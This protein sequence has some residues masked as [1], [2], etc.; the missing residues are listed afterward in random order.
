MRARTAGQPAVIGRIS[1]VADDH[2]L[3]ARLS[4]RLADAQ[5]LVVALP[6]GKRREG[7]TRRLIAVTTAAKRNLPA[8]S[9]RLDALLA[10]LGEDA[11]YPDR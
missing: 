6:E 11:E 1:R 10:E 5:R 7:L 9:R 8:A 2:E 4:R 3:L